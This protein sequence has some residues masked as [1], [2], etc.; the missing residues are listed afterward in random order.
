[1]AQHDYNIANATFPATRSDINS[2]LSA[3][4]TS[5]SGT[6]RPSSAVEGT[7]WLDTTNATSPTLKFYD[8]TDDISLATLDYVANT[9]NWIDS[10]V[11]IDIVNDL[12]PELGGNLSLNSNDI[13]GTGNINIT[14]N[15]T[16]TAFS[17]DGSGLT[18]VGGGA[19]EIISRTVAS[20]T[21]EVIYDF[22]SYTNYDGFRIILNNITPATNNVEFLL[23]FG[24]N[25]TNFDTDNEVG[26]RFELNDVGNGLFSELLSADLADEVGS[27]ADEDG[28][29]GEIFI[30]KSI[31]NT[32]QKAHIT[33]YLIAQNYTANL[34]SMFGSALVAELD[35]EDSIRLE[36]N[37]GSIESGIFTLLGLK[38]S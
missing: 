38:Q 23:H 10:T 12:S 35:A 1:M 15:I 18:G 8:G 31:S 4:N 16:G 17:G 6:S 32:S 2:V 30:S 5:N 25:G 28:V 13:T 37:A 34:G 11:V 19:Y 3:I 33:T 7:V 20:S 9:V 36:F 29:S 27:A 26:V 22:G 24:Q 14:G 21:S